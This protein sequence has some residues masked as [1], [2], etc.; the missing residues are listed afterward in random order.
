M[1]RQNSLDSGPANASR[2]VSAAMRIILKFL[3]GDTGP[4]GGRGM[5]GMLSGTTLKDDMG[6]GLEAF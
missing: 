3:R 2:K 1:C 5:T 4:Y 6:N